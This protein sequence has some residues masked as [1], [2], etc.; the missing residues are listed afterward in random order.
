MKDAAACVLGIAAL[1]LAC[2]AARAD[3]AAGPDSAE[4][5]LRSWQ[6]DDGLP[7]S[8][9][10]A[11]VQTPDGY[12]WFGTFRGLVR[13]D[14]VR[15]AV[16]DP[17]NTP[18]LPSPEVVN[19]HLDRQQRL[20]VSTYGG[21]VVRDGTRWLDFTDAPVLGQDLV[22]TFA[23]RND[24]ALLL[25]TFQ[26]RVIE[27]NGET[28]RPLP[29]PP[30]EAGEGYWGGVDDDGHWW[31]AQ[32]EFV[33][34]WNG[35]AWVRMIP[36]A[37]LAG[38]EREEIACCP[39]RDGGLW[40]LCGNTL[41]RFVRDTEVVRR[42]LPEVPH[43]IWSVCEDDD[44]NL[45][46]AS[47]SHGVYQLPAHAPLRHWTEFAGTRQRTF[48]FVFHDQEH[49]LWLGTSGR[50]LIRLTTRRFHD[51][52]TRDMLDV[53]V[54]SL[55]ANPNGGL[56]VA[57][58]GDGLFQLD[59]EGLRRVNVPDL[60]GAGHFIQSVLADHAGRT[61]LGLFRG[62]LF[63]FDHTHGQWVVGGEH[64]PMNFIALFEDTRERIW[65][66]DGG[67]AI[68][69]DGQ[70]TRVFG[71]DE[72]LPPGAVVCFAEDDAHV[73][74]L[75]NYTGVFR[76]V[77]DRVVELRDATGHSFRDILCLKSDTDGTMWLG[78]ASAGLLRWRDGV[79][80][81]VGPQQGLPVESVVGILDDGQGY[82]WLA[83][84][85]GVVRAA[86]RD[87]NAVADAQTPQLPCQLFN[88]GD[89]LPTMECTGMRQPVC[90]RDAGGR[91]WFATTK[92]VGMADPAN[93]PLNAVP[94]NVHIENLRY[95]APSQ[96]LG[97]HGQPNRT[98][99]APFA[100]VIRLP[101]GSRGIEIHY[102]APSFAA[103]EKVR[104]QVQ[105]EDVDPTWRDV[106]NRR[107]A[108]YDAPR[109]GPYRFR[110]RAANGDG[111]WNYEGASLD[112][113][114]LPYFWE[115]GW[116]RVLAVLAVC[117]VVLGWAYRLHARDK[118][119]QALQAAFT[120]QLI[121]RQEAER[122]RVASELH[123]SLGHDLL[124]IKSRLALLAK[125][126][127]CETDA[128][129]QLE[130]VSADVT[131]AIGDVRTIS[132]ALRPSALTQVGLTHAITWMIEELRNATT[133]QFDTEFDTIDGVLTPEREINLYRIL[134]EALNNVIKHA[135]ATHVAVAITRKPATIS[136]QVQDNGCGFDLRRLRAEKRPTFGLTG[137]A[138]RA[139]LLGGRVDVTSAPGMGTR[140]IVT[141]PAQG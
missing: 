121:A 104:F 21:V 119:Q 40:L 99:A 136:I 61:W 137:L 5:L 79:V 89:G 46:M 113:V 3:S 34:E 82:F 84:G 20:W 31:V 42:T 29:Q 60:P 74:W 130:E 97:D 62:G 30:G 115:T 51:F 13:F 41:R 101:A 76:I 36:A 38:V 37:E 96:E 102:T 67:Q 9:A 128:G 98:L 93:F 69:F 75:T 57:T 139:H 50:G 24:G 120:H 73:I 83:S 140:V 44:G 43:G 56:L 141:V 129:N 19:L 53:C 64:K 14:G 132:R 7:D 63:A 116:F 11:M 126:A 18:E 65:A 80:R 110:V 15:F 10:T 52:G 106:G 103:P 105:M 118:H 109:P 28:L 54:T 90:L 134:Q 16:F 122:S 100:K 26:G 87:L 66:S 6:I 112:F 81:P 22:R 117:G 91:L 88:A 94:P 49:N 131:R 78:S 25:T 77:D 55:T 33:G 92:G 114:V 45:W 72:G 47:Y 4:W 27:W 58:Y 71:P 135:Q 2:A 111:V 107:V 86:R 48:R 59:K 1:A 138:E 70:T 124:L 23:E 108:F 133:I 95:H 35:Q 123:D 127:A 32:N 12:L 39:A 125:G 85:S 8:S 68:M 17:Q